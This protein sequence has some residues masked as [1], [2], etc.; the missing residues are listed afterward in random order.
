MIIGIVGLHDREAVQA[1]MNNLLPSGGVTQVRLLNIGEGN[2]DYS[3]ALAGELAVVHDFERFVVVGFEELLKL[4]TDLLEVLVFLNSSYKNLDECCKSAPSLMLKIVDEI[5][6]SGV[7]SKSLHILFGDNYRG[8][9]QEAL[10]RKHLKTAGTDVSDFRFATLSSVFSISKIL[11]SLLNENKF[12]LYPKQD[13]GIYCFI[14]SGTVMTEESKTSLIE[15]LGDKVKLLEE[16]FTGRSSFDYPN[17]EGTVLGRFMKTYAQVQDWDVA[18]SDEGLCSRC[19][20]ATESVLYGIKT[21]VP[22]FLPAN[23]ELPKLPQLVVRHVADASSFVETRVGA[24]S[25]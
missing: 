22:V 18:L 14:P 5:T 24:L 16:I 15:E 19:P 9:V 3:R 10:L 13:G 8:L 23:E 11:N 20:T 2:M 25:E 12:R 7:G 17:I 4:G 1:F 6:K 21:G